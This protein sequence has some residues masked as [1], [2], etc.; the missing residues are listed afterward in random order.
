MTFAASHF[1][2]H[3]LAEGPMPP[4][5]TS[6]ADAWDPFTTS[7]YSGA[8]PFS[9]VRDAASGR[10]LMRNVNRLTEPEKHTT[11][12]WPRD[13]LKGSTSYLAFEVAWHDFTPRGW[14]L[15][16]QLQMTGS[17]VWALSNDERDRHWFLTVRDGSKVTKYPLGPLVLDHIETFVIGAHL[18]DKPGGLVE[19]WHGADVS[20]APA[21]H[22]PGI[23]TWQ[24]T[25]GHHTLGIYAERAK[26][27]QYVADFGRVGRAATAAQAIAEMLKAAA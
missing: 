1:P 25:T 3:P 6:K 11:F 19:C 14:S 10:K 21:V 23:D 27:G 22:V 18:A 7:L 26:S 12:G 2:M 17:P 16:A 20:A 24:G 5:P 8:N 15:V 13:L 9:V 4:H